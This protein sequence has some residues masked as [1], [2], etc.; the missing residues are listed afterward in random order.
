MG[1]E[2]I[3][4]QSRIRHQQVGK[5]REPRF[6]V[7]VRVPVE[8]FPGD[9]TKSPESLV[10]QARERGLVEFLTPTERYA[11]QDLFG[12]GVNMTRADCARKD[13]V[14]RQAVDDR[15]DRALTK[16]L[17]VLRGEAPTTAEQ[18][19][20]QR[21]LAAIESVDAVRELLNSGYTKPQIRRQLGLRKNDIALIVHEF[22]INF[23]KGRPPKPKSPAENVV[24]D[25]QLF[26]KD[27]KPRKRIGRPPRNREFVGSAS[28]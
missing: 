24:V 15:I 26:N 18:I 14:T 21:T 11:V 17:R 13:G 19:R 25:V 3:E 28:A 2:T 1:V 23:R 27:G 22:G 8:I 4:R 12:S 10:Q 9:G 16:I 6:E 5:S 7:P 20:F